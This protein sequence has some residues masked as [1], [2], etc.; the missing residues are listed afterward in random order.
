MLAENLDEDRF[1]QRRLAHRH[2]CSGWLFF[3]RMRQKKFQYF[4]WASSSLVREKQ[5]ARVIDQNAVLHLE[6][7]SQSVRHCRMAPVHPTFRG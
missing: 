4:L 6:S 5:V 2:Y 7:G 3:K 1:P